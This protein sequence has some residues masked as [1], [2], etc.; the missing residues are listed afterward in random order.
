M[1]SKWWKGSKQ[2]VDFV[3]T[4]TDPTG[5]LT[6]GEV[7][8]MPFQVLVQQGVTTP[9]LD[10]PG[11]QTPDLVDA[12]VDGASFKVSILHMYQALEKGLHAV[13]VK[14]GPT[15]EEPLYQAVT[16]VVL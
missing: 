12:E 4:M 8:G 2:Y 6:L 15:P 9:E 10:D 14:F 7:E 16:F 1:D 3:V 13:F 11:W 5:D